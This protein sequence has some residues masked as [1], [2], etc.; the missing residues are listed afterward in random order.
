MCPMRGAL[1]RDSAS[2]LWTFCFSCCGVHTVGPFYGGTDYSRTIDRE[3][4]DTREHGCMYTALPCYR[5]H[6]VTAHRTPPHTPVMGQGSSTRAKM[7]L[8]N[9]P[10]SPQ[11]VAQHLARLWRRVQRT[12]GPNR[13]A[14]PP[15]ARRL[16]PAHH[17]HRP[18]PRCEQSLALPPRRWRRPQPPAASQ[19]LG[20]GLRA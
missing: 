6:T 5:L 10:R 13:P 14:L 16:A 17:L 11:P 2:R 1:S 18:A 19:A 15:G 7:S 4:T 12:L 20:L 3:H 9:H 8:P